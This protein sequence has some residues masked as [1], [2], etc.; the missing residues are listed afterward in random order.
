MY[1]TLGARLDVVEMLDGL[2][3]GADRDL[4]RVWEKMNKPRFDRV[5]LKTKTVAVEAKPDALCVTFEGEQAPTEP[6]PYDL[7]LLAVGRSPNGKKIGADK[8]GVAVTERGFIPVDNQMRTNVPHIFAIGDIVGQP[9]LAHK[10]AHEGHVAAEA[11]AGEKSFF[12]AR[13]IPSVA[14]TDPEIA[15]VGLTEDEAK[16]KG[17]KVEQGPVPVGRVGPRDRQRPRRGLHQAALRRDDAPDRRRRHRRHARRRPDQRDRARDRDGRR[18]GRHRPDH[19]SAS[20]AVR[21]GRPRRRGV[22]RRVHRPAAAAEEIAA[23]TRRPA[24]CRA[25]LAARK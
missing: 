7:V 4:V 16:A 18:R 23:P 8:A 15:W 3:P 14:Y 10:A 9:M 19:P 5:M 11:A 25:S 13:V 17:V 1:S 6:Q 20:D 24:A 2:M 21:I 22:R 12:D